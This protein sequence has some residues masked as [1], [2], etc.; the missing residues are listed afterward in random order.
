MYK[1]I[2]GNKQWGHFHSATMF[3]PWNILI[4]RSSSMSRYSCLQVNVYEMSAMLIVELI[5]DIGS[6]YNSFAKAVQI[7][8]DL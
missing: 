2:L 1:S 6:H 4:K 8:A 3:C 5:E 7:D